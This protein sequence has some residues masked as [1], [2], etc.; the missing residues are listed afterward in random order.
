MEHA[1]VLG[2]YDNDIYAQ[3]HK[4]MAWLGRACRYEHTSRVFNGN[5][6]D[7][8]QSDQHLDAGETGKYSNQRQPRSTSKATAGKCILIS[9]HDLEE[10]LQPA[11]T[12][13]RRQAWASR[14]RRNA[15]CA[16]LPG[17]A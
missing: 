12:D 6:P 4:I 15:A 10:S 7:E 11:G 16:W 5:R 3:Y 17:A 1:H 13:R 8:L 14:P 9:G 2:Q